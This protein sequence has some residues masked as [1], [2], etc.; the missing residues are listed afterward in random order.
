MSTET[1][2]GLQG[3]E[4]LTE[5]LQFMVFIDPSIQ[6]ENIYR[7]ILRKTDPEA[8]VGGKPF[9]AIWNVFELKFMEK[10]LMKCEKFLKSIGFKH[11]DFNWYN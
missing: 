2:L 9:F 11:K 4:E 7:V 8:T 6:E 10:L 1:S 3:I 5:F